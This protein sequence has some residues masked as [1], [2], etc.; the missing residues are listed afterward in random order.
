MIRTNGRMAAL[1]A[2]LPKAEALDGAL[3]AILA[4]GFVE[5]G[6]CL[7][8]AES[9]RRRDHAARSDFE[10][11]TGYECFVNRVDV[12]DYVAGSELVAQG[13][14]FAEEVASS[15]GAKGPCTV[16]VSAGDAT[17]SV[18][19][20]RTRSGE[21]WLADDLEGYTHEAILAIHVP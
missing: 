16:I 13:V 7:F 15:L 20:H 5:E 10:D 21:S 3:A 14:R 17:C 2:N 19:F 12:D 8:F 1:M 6:G 4:R 11:A 9:A 18:R